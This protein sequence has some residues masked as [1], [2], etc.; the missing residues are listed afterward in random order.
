MLEAQQVRTR[1]CKTAAV[2]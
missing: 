1:N 2:T